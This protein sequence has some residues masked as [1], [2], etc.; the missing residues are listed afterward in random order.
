MNSIVETEGTQATVWLIVIDEKIWG[1]VPSS[2]TVKSAFKF[3]ADKFIADIKSLNPTCTVEAVQLT[4]EKMQIKCIQPGYVFNSEW[5]AHTII[6]SPVKQ[7]KEPNDNQSPIL[8]PFPEKGDEEVAKGVPEEAPKEEPVVFSGVPGPAQIEEKIADIVAE[9][10]A[11][12]ETPVVPETLNESPKQSNKIKKRS[13][14]NTPES[15]PVEVII[16][17]ASQAVLVP[18]V[19]TQPSIVQLDQPTHVEAPKNL[20]SSWERRKPGT[21][22]HISKYPQNRLL[23]KK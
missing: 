18:A 20:K 10:T 11:V 23:K 13:R 6:A 5:I 7:Y 22:S 15:T 21:V 12:P 9:V 19:E 16:Q 8:I 3:L 17:K 4:E 1:Y 14:Q 2:D